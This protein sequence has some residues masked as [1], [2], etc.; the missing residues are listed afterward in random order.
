MS[1]GDRRAQTW[2][3]AQFPLMRVGSMVLN[4]N[5]ENFFND[6][7]QL[8]YSPGHIVPGTTAA[9][10]SM[11]CCFPLYVLACMR[12]ITGEKKKTTKPK[13]TSW[14]LCLLTCA[15]HACSQLRFG[16]SLVLE[17]PQA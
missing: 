1:A 16:S 6:N 3:E 5:P 8:A 17:A 12:S 7:E 10:A 14:P 15:A 9:H 4:Q 11:L 13:K 2:P